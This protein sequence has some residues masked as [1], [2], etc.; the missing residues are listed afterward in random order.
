[1]ASAWKGGVLYQKNGAICL[2]TQNLPDCINHSDAFK[3]DSVLRPGQAY[4][5]TARYEFQI[6]S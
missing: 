3:E 1:M 6:L 5:H 2:E 4:T